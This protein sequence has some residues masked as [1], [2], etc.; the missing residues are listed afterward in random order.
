MDDKRRL[1]ALTAM[2]RWREIGCICLDKDPIRWNITRYVS[3][4]LRILER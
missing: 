3:D 2:R 1:V 4:F